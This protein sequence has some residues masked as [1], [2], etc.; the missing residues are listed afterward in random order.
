MEVLTTITKHP[1]YVP[2][3]VRAFLYYGIDPNLDEPSRSLYRFLLG[4]SKIL[5]G[6]R[7][8]NWPTMENAV[9][10]VANSEWAK[11]MPTYAVRS[12]FTSLR[13]GRYIRHI[14]HTGLDKRVME[15]IGYIGEKTK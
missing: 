4:I 2:V 5:H 10:E 12:A 6:L 11:D 7:Y 15:L 14:Y 9:I 1:L 3:K 13:K 8:C